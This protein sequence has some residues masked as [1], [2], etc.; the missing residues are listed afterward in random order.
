ME[1]RRVGTTD[2]YV[3]PIGIGCMG[4]SHAYGTPTPK[5]E[6]IEILRKAIEIGYNFF[7]TAE[8]YIGT[9]PDGSISYNEEIVGEAVKPFREKVVV[10]TKFGVTHQGRDLITDSSPE[11]IRKS[12]EGSLKRLQMSYVDIYDQHRIDPK[13]EP[14]VVAGV[15]KELIQEG[16]IK[17]WGISE[18]NEDYLRRAHKVCPVTVIQNRYSM[19]ARGH[20]KMFPICEELGIT[21]VAYSPIAN[22]FMSGAY[23]EKSQFNEKGDYRASM[24]QFK[25][26]GFKSAEQLM[27]E[28][29]QIADQKKATL[30]Q[31]SLAWIINKHH[32]CIPIPGSRKVSRL[33]ENFH[34]GDIVLTPEEIKHIDDLLDKA[35][36]P[37][38]GVNK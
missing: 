9:N 25:E 4:L 6:A 13:V 21:F 20:E 16:K 18:V 36:I 26:G 27:E 29:K 31:L 12:I 10:C 2:N 38:F 33:E 1:K 22:G 23:N 19:L 32:N 5:A 14:E 37:V 28:L 34:A 7:D 11:R 24:P 17:C 30:A 35:D 8:C 3:N 15:M